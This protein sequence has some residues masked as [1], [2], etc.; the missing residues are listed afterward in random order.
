[1]L[2]RVGSHRLQRCRGSTHCQERHLRF[3]L[4]GVA[5]AVLLLHQIGACVEEHRW[6]RQ[7]GEDCD[8]LTEFV[9]QATQG[10]DDERRIGDG[11]ATVIERVDEALEVLIR[12]LIRG[13]STQY[14]AGGPSS[15]NAI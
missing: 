6:Q 4:E 7:G 9:I 5:D 12:A 11:G 14:M 3:H 10:V 1:L 2:G 13:R 8:G 15:R